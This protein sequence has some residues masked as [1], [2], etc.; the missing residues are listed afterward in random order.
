MNA[1][2]CILVTVVRRKTRKKKA[3]TRRETYNLSYYGDRQLITL[4]EISISPPLL[5]L[6]LAG[7]RI[8]TSSIPSYLRRLPIR[9]VSSP[10]PG[11]G[12]KRRPGR[13]GH[14]LASGA[15]VQITTTVSQGLAS[16]VLRLRQPAVGTAGRGQLYRRGHQSRVLRRHRVRVRGP[17]RYGDQYTQ[18]AAQVRFPRGRLQEVTKFLSLAPGN[19]L[20][21]TVL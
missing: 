7:V 12:T 4:I 3:A 10:R 14:V 9:Q 20:V 17:G 15:T 13:R 21:L 5:F 19:V 18:Q 1:V 11:G 8:K 16:G 2:Y 6:S